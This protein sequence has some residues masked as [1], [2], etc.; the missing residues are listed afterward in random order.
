MV[1][2]SRYSIFFTLLPDFLTRSF[3]RSVALFDSVKTKWNNSIS[4]ESMKNHEMDLNR[5]ISPEKYKSAF[6]HTKPLDRQCLFLSTWIIFN[7]SASIS[8][9]YFYCS[10]SRRKGFNLST[11]TASNS[12]QSFVD[13]MGSVRV[14]CWGAGWDSFAW[15]MGDANDTHTQPSTSPMQMN[16]CGQQR[17]FDWILI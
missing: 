12:N 14:Y 5:F 10:D 11:G 9:T 13:G 3:G 8:I 4:L 15:W 16:F 2:L 17:R 7:R 6:G 1:L